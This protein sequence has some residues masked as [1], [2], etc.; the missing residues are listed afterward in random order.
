MCFLRSV[1]RIALRSLKRSEDV[2]KNY[3][4]I[5]I[6]VEFKTTEINGV[7]MAKGERKS[8]PKESFELCCK[9]KKEC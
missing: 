6:Q 4:L 3:R 7:N 5:I 2:G 9:T 8:Y 1:A